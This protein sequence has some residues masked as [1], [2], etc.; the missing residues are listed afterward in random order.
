MLALKSAPP[1]K[2]LPLA[3]YCWAHGYG[4]Y[5]FETGQ[6]PP[7]I[8]PQGVLTLAAIIAIGPAKGMSTAVTAGVDKA[9]AALG[10]VLAEAVLVLVFVLGLGKPYY[11]LLYINITITLCIALPRVLF[12]RTFHEPDLALRS[13]LPWFCACLSTAP[14][15][16][17]GDAHPPYR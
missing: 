2:C 12:V 8:D 9:N 17:A 7:E 14:S 13:D 5:L 4:H 15:P 6:A 11:A 10:A 3:A 16:A 1:A